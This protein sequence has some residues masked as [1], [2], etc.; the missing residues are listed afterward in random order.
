MNVTD[1]PS[2]T[3]SAR[4][5]LRRQAHTWHGRRRREQERKPNREPKCFAKSMEARREGERQV[6]VVR[7]GKASC[8]RPCSTPQ[9]AHACHMSQNAKACN[10]VSRHGMSS[11]FHLKCLNKEQFSREWIWDCHVVATKI[12]WKVLSIMF[13]KIKKY[14]VL[15]IEEC[16]CPVCLR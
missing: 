7:W 2:R 8:P 10:F 5:L 6:G 16:H 9:P 12:M 15:F 3:W 14:H 13:Y 4:K 1:E 11:S